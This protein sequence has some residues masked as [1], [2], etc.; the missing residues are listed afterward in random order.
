MSKY[1]NDYLALVKDVMEN[2][3]M[4]DNRT[5]HKTKYISGAMLKCD[6]S[7]GFPLLT[8]SRRGYK[9]VSAELEC[10]I[11]GITD[12]RMFQKRKCRIW[13]EWC[14]PKKVA[15]GHNKDDYKRMSEEPDLGKVYGYQWSHFGNTDTDSVVCVKRRTIPKDPSKKLCYDDSVCCKGEFVESYDETIFDKVYGV[16]CDFTS[17]CYKT[18]YKSYAEYGGKG[19]F[20]DKRWM[21][22]SNFL[23]D[24]DELPNFSDMI[25]NIDDYVL[26]INYYGGN[27]YSKDVCVWLK[28][29]ESELYKN[30]E[31]FVAVNKKGDEK[32]FISLHKASEELGCSV[33]RIASVLKGKQKST[34]G[35]SFAYARHGDDVVYRY[36]L[37]TNQLRYVIETAKSDPTS[38]RLMCVA[39]NPTQLDEM[40]LTPCVYSWQILIN[41]ETNKMDLVYY[42]RSADLILGVP[43]NISSYS[44]LLILLCEELGYEVGSVTALMSNVHIY[45]NHFEKVEELLGR[46]TY[47]LPTIKLKKFDGIYNFSYDDFEIEN[48]K[49][50][51]KITFDV[52][53]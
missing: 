10:F 27:A 15:Y 11:K 4:S 16:W 8:G 38:R 33:T 14:N 46:E 23:D 51:D 40:S 36:K 50:N 31:L 9:Y 32:S 17:K 43:A 20:V 22:F 49:C 1:E 30:S 53:I 42:Q 35:W 7:E 47:D 2:G 19:V 45:E 21:T 41:T 25:R 52:A 3:C 5:A 48:Y 26:D 34:G 12:K 6:L 28:K 39:W 24:C 37:P 13:D 18:N 44:M 29:G